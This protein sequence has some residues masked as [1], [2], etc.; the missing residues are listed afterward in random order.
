MLYYWI[1]FLLC[2]IQL[3]NLGHANV[4]VGNINKS[5]SRITRNGGDRLP[6]THHFS[7]SRLMIRSREQD[8]VEDTYIQGFLTLHYFLLC[9]KIS[10]SVVEKID[11]QVVM[12][13]S[14]GYCKVANRRTSHLVGPPK[15]CSDCLWRGNLMSI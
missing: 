1:S 3:G 11:V 14:S 5:T 2:S 8:W 12:G 10:F 13:G 4:E 9:C 6:Q 15:R 7:I